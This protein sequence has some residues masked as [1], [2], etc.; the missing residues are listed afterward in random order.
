M[1]PRRTGP[2]LS[3]QLRRLNPPARVLVVESGDTHRH[4]RAPHGLTLTILPSGRIGEMTEEEF[5]K[6][7]KSHDCILLDP[8]LGDGCL[9]L[10]VLSD[11][12]QRQLGDVASG[13][14]LR[15][16]RGDGEIVDQRRIWKTISDLLGDGVAQLRTATLRR[17]RQTLTKGRN[18]R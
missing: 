13:L 16:V 6:M 12:L 8:G 4:R 7:A 5:T 10:E 11:S 18:A 17:L 3:T 2:P 1:T 14:I 9:F 15:Q